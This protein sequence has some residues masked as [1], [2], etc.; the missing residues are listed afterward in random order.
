M[1]LLVPASSVRSERSFR[2]FED[3]SV[4]LMVSDHYLARQRCVSHR[5]RQTRAPT[6]PVHFLFFLRVHFSSAFKVLANS[7]ARLRSSA[8]GLPL[9]SPPNSPRK[10]FVLK[11]AQLNSPTIV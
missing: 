5:S 8:L 1:T 11:P 6:E 3:F 9:F 7:S 4:N 10:L 2:S